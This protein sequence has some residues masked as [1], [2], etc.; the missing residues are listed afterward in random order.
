MDNLVTFKI[1]FHVKKVLPAEEGGPCDKDAPVLDFAGAGDPLALRVCCIDD[2]PLARKML[3]NLFEKNLGPDSVRTYGAS[4]DECST[5]LSSALS[6]ATAVI[7]D[8]NL[9]F[10]T[11]TVF[12]TDLVTAL[13][14]RNFTGFI[15]MRSANNDTKD[16]A[17]Y[18]ASGV[19]CVL[20][21]DL[22]MKEFFRQFSAGL[23]THGYTVL[24][25]EDI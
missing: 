3:G 21:K 12:S 22:R 19:H 18:K 7:V 2:A 20:P 4:Q 6:W 13:H 10:P 8:Q 14:D 15:C 25:L 5:F 1:V 16:V 23:R 11:G 17:L 24:D 9:D